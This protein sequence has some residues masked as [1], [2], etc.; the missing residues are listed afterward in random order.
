MDLFIGSWDG[1]GEFFDGTV[2]EAALYARVL[3]AAQIKGHYD[4]GVAAPSGAPATAAATA[5]VA[6]PATNDAGTIQALALTTPL[7]P[8]SSAPVSAPPA[9]TAAPA[10]TAT[11]ASKKAVRTARQDCR[12]LKGKKRKRCLRNQ[13]QQGPQQ[14]RR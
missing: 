1:V 12:K 8:T 5:P 7:A 14:G 9:T 10:T 6:A 13:Q 2:D 4:S 11:P 3:S